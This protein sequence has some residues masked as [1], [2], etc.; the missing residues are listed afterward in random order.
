MTKLFD[1]DSLHQATEVVINTTAKT[2][3]LLA[4]GNLSAASPAAVN[5]VTGQAVYSFLKEEWKTDG[6][7]NKF[8]FPLF[9]YTKT[10]G[11]LINGWA[12]ADATTR[13]L[14]R[15]FGWTEGADQYAGLASLGD[16]H[17]D[18]D[19]AYY[20]QSP[21][22]DAATTEFQFTGELN[23]A[24]EITGLTSY[25]KAFLRV[26]GKTPAE[27]DLVREQNLSLLE[28]VLYKFPF[29]N[30]IDINIT[31]TDVNIAANAP[32]TGMKI[33]YLAGTGFTQAAAQS[34][35]L[36]AVIRDTAGR[37]AYCSS[38]GTL[39]AAGVADYTANGGTGTFVAYD[40]ERQIGANYYAFNRLI[41][42]NNATSEE[43]YNWMQWIV[44]EPTDINA[45]D[46]PTAGQ[47]SGLTMNGTNA[48]LLG[49]FVGDN[50]HTLGGVFIDDFHTNSTNNLTFGAITVDA[51]GL[52]PVTHVPEAS[53]PIFFPFTAAGTLEFSTNLVN[54]PNAD[55]RYVM[56]FDNAG[57]NLFDS[58]N[59]IIVDNNA[60]TDID[61]E[62]TGASIAWDFDYDGN[63]QG[64]RTFGTDA[65]VHVVA[66]G[67]N[68]AQW[69][70]V[71]Y[72]IT[73]STGQTINVNANDER[74]YANP[75]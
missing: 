44:R 55:T 43:I 35:A 27:Y 63:T 25:I 48:E 15:D 64:G 3:Q 53:T 73:R 23:E 26:E 66:Q 1:P 56:Y 45:N 21:A 6:A 17:N 57:G 60:G 75:A 69:V 4:T 10:D 65:L 7:L 33:N 28:P 52:D 37:W 61:G 74:N 19:Q 16:I 49:F 30:A 51:G 50:L 72:T 24:V 9:M 54:E 62:V 47:R 34:Y 11:V 46:S 42:A 14:L 68:S 59:A 2:I 38:P 32:Y 36:G 71:T 20:T 67:L 13:S 70:E 5:G 8:K 18:A 39:N 58:A 31:E 22:Y 12:W 41:D 29:S 40:G